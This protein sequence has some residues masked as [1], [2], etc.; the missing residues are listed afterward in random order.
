MR[1]FRAAL[2]AV[3]L[4]GISGTVGV[5]T[6]ESAMA[7][8]SRELS[9]AAFGD[10]V[11]DA[12]HQ[13]VFISDPKSGKV[14]ATDYRGA[15]VAELTGLPGVLDLVLSADSNSIYAA[16]PDAHAIVELSTTSVTESDR[17]PVGDTISPAGVVQTDDRLWFS[18]A[19]TDAGGFGSVDPDT[20]AVHLY[21][22]GP[23]G[24]SYPHRAPLL[25]AKDSTL[26]TVVVDDGS[27]DVA[28]FDLA[29]GAET[30]R[31]HRT[32]ASR[33]WLADFDFTADGAGLIGV[34]GSDRFRISLSD[35]TMTSVFPN[36]YASYAT[37]TA[38]DGLVAI[39]TENNNNAA[40]VRVY[41][42]GV[43]EPVLDV[44]LEVNRQDYY[45]SVVADGLAWEPG[46]PR[47]FAVGVNWR[48]TDANAPEVYKYRLFEL[49]APPHYASSMWVYA[50][51]S[52]G[53]LDQPLEITGGLR[54]EVLP[55]AGTEVTVT[56]TDLGS[57][58][59]KVVGTVQTDQS[60]EFRFTDQPSAG[61]SVTYTV[62]YPGSA[63]YDPASASVVVQVARPK[64]ALKLD[65][66]AGRVAYGQKVTFTAT[67]GKTHQNRVLEIWSQPAGQES[68]LVTRGTVNSAGKLVTTIAL[69]R[70]TTV[71]AKFTGDARYAPNSWSWIVQTQVQASTTLSKHYKTMK[72]GS[73]SYYVFRTS[74]DPQITN[75]MTAYPGRIEHTVVE[76]YSGGRWKPWR[77]G[78]YKLGSTGKTSRALAGTFKP[79]SRFR[80]R[81]EYVK[82]SH[83]N[84]SVNASTNGS[85]KY[86][87]FT[88]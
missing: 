9:I 61:G 60:G 78:W 77:N 73:L 20:R 70:N 34:G 13:R 84:D 15:P 45:G 24:I 68:R 19:G 88:K 63:L 1:M 31:I 42:D 71:T 38:G 35:L 85:W 7:A 3:V 62:S 28:V 16:V 55:P 87:T 32:L 48:S 66:S 67:L 27:Y 56:R 36:Y 86:F 37:E 64:P 39:S 82:G 11:V 40:D 22:A 80:V 81:T 52:G 23:D 46:G 4:A 6:A 76:V 29:A 41:R 75:T 83:G 47:L 10:M 17:F 21:E 69:T 65:V 57:P 54:A 18:Y 26:V 12:T 5:L 58:S 59:G 51:K 74:K 43:S 33:G 72:I 50:G 2:A 30:L 25:Y 79:G 44:N 8:S 49:N 14:V 53:T